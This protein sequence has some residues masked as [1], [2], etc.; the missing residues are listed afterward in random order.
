VNEHGFGASLMLV[1]MALVGLLCLAIGDAANVL[2]SRA[3]AQSAADAAALA[4]ASAAWPFLA[5]GD[6]SAAARATADA[7]GAQLESC[8]CPQRGPSEVVV[9]SVATRIRML[10]VAPRRVRAGAQA[11]LDP[12]RM[13]AA[14]SQ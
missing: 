11:S 3:R 5:E 8:V 14:P 12:G 9:V 13:F 1:M 10:G 6:P 2:T 7:N 4:A